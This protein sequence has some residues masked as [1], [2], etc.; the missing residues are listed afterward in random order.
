MKK[1]KKIESSLIPDEDNIVYAPYQVSKRRLH[2]LPKN[3]RNVRIEL[4]WI[5]DAS[6]EQVIGICSSVEDI[7]DT[8]SHYLYEIR[9]DHF[10]AWCSFRGI[11][12]DIPVSDIKGYI[13]LSYSKAWMAYFD[14]VIQDD[15]SFNNFVII[16]ISYKPEDVAYILK[17]Y[18]TLPRLHTFKD[19]VSEEPFDLEEEEGE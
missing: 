8:L 3:K 9:K 1:L 19:A 17:N 6:S 2:S 12:P 18:L 13:P 7:V 14:T 5:T 16:A 10:E 11:Q 4:Y 15:P